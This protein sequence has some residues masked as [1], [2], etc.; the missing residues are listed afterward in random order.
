M[1]KQMFPLT[2]F[3]SP[4]TLGRSE[5]SPAFGPRRQHWTRTA[6]ATCQSHG[7]ACSLLEPEDCT[8]D[9]AHIL[10]RYLTSGAIYQRG[11]LKSDKDNVRY[12]TIQFE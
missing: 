9:S 10:G 6:S 8:G 3:V 2:G 4:E 5:M 1:S 11:Q 12:I 7:S